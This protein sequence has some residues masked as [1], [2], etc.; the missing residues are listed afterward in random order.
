MRPT[1]LQTRYRYDLSPRQREVM[2]L[3]QRGLTNAEIADRLGLTL[4]GAKYHVREILGK[5]G[6]ESREEAV[7]LWREMPGRPRPWERFGLV[8]AV[9]AGATAMIVVAAAVVLALISRDGGEDA[10]G[11]ATVSPPPT[12]TVA[13]LPTST[14]PGLAEC[15]SLDVTLSLETVPRAEDVLV[16]LSASGSNP[17]RML[18]PFTLWLIRPPVDPGPDYPPEAN[19][20]RF[21]KIALDFPFTG[22][23]GEWSWRN[24]C[25]EPMSWVFWQAK[26]PGGSGP[27]V[28]LSNDFWPPCVEAT[29]PSILE[30]EALYAG[31]DGDPTPDPQCLAIAARWLCTFVTSVGADATSDG[32]RLFSTG[33]TN[34]AYFLCD[35]AGGAPGLPPDSR[36][37]DG[38]PANTSVPG[39]W[40]ETS[41]PPGTFVTRTEFEA[42]VKAALSTSTRPAAFSCL[43]ANGYSCGYPAVVV[44][45]G[46]APVALIFRLEGGREPGMVGAA[47]LPGGPLPELLDTP[48]GTFTFIPYPERP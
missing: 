3:L 21:M 18:G 38:H 30:Q 15:T 46:V 43:P 8:W 36:I 47:V 25:A 10:P 17:C 1:H 7:A 39:Y 27:T 32:M 40:L 45:F 48:F 33:L 2:E 11:E 34:D 31:I 12:A 13:A 29:A 41:S 4:D 28:G 14:A 24:W 35:G 16:R 22:V 5:L 37:C 42:E 44:D 23:L 20:N 6:V 9:A 26:A 19:T